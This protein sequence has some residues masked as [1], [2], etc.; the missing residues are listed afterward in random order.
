MYESIPHKKNNRDEHSILKKNQFSS[1]FT[2][3]HQFPTIIL[4]LQGMGHLDIQYF[5]FCKQ[6]PSQ[7]LFIKDTLSELFLTTFQE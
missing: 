1:V 7:V 4:L 6:Q 2:F 3:G 5:F